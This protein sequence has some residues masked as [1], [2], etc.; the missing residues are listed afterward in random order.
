MTKKSHSE[1][2]SELSQANN[3][4]T[5][6]YE[7]GFHLVPTVLEDGVAAIVEKVRA[8]LGDAEIINEQ[9]PARMVLAYTIERSVQGKREKYQDAYFGF[10]KFALVREEVQAFQAKLRAIPEVLR[11]I[12][13]ETVREDMPAPR[14]A[15]FSSRQLEGETI[16]KPEAPAEKAA[17]VSEEEL[18][19]SIDALVSQE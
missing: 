12:V 11:F 4:E 1:D 15:I 5:P 10:I 6:V 19:K 7:L 9:F 2:A 18:D 8:T 14:R 3:G 16:K 17:E 13:I